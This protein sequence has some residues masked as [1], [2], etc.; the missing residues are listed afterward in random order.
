MGGGPLPN[1]LHPPPGLGVDG[2]APGNDDVYLP[3]PS[4]VKEALL[5][6]KAMS[7]R[8]DDLL[9]KK[10]HAVART[11]EEPVSEVV[12][13]ALDQY[14]TERLADPAFRARVKERTEEDLAS[15]KEI[16]G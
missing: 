8:L 1:R 13:A 16:L 10:V 12:R 4:G 3:Q 6:M 15:M 11:E 2:G 9:A 7:L 14:V 5:S